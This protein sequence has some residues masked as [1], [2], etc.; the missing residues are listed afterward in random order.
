M[1]YLLLVVLVSCT[2]HETSSRD[3]AANQTVDRSKYVIQPE[4]WA[5][6][7][8]RIDRD[9][10]VYP[11]DSPNAVEY[12]KCLKSMDVYLD[13]DFSNDNFLA[14]ECNSIRETCRLKYE[15][16]TE[17]GKAKETKI[18]QIG[19]ACFS[20]SLIQ[21]AMD[22]DPTDVLVKSCN[23][24]VKRACE[25]HKE[26]LDFYRQRNERRQREYEATLNT[27]SNSNRSYNASPNNNAVEDFRKAMFPKQ[28]QKKKTR[29]TT[30][31][32]AHFNTYESVCE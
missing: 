16:L 1:K 29:C 4:F 12:K 7:K 31:Y 21:I 11:G 19:Y 5:Q 18:T 25:M 10:E 2:T 22:L 9:S 8:E 17:S 24:G 32:N 30:E 15:E 26:V 3:D 6:F 14:P 23:Y 27:I 13:H 20:F 28:E